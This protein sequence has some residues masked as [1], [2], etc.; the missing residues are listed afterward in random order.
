MYDELIN[1]FLEIVNHPSGVCIAKVV[2]TRFKDDPER[3]GGI[4]KLAAKDLDIIIQNPYGNY[5]IQHM[6]TVTIFSFLTVKRIT[7]SN[8]LRRLLKKLLTR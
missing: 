6:I 5:A 7:K 2:I 1:H 8:N 3:V 4:V